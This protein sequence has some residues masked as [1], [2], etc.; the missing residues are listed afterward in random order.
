MMVRYLHEALPPAIR[1]QIVLALALSPVVV[2]L[3]HPPGVL[4][5]RG[6]VVQH[7]G[8]SSGTYRSIPLMSQG[9]SVTARNPC[10]IDTIHGLMA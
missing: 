1:A 8:R 2:V 3:L 10:K 4:S 6:Q 9:C 5:R 7:G